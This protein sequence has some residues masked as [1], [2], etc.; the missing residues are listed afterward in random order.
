MHQIMPNG[1][2]KPLTDQL[3][4]LLQEQLLK[5]HASITYVHLQT[6]EKLQGVAFKAPSSTV[7]KV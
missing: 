5:V 2:K 3:A 1:V 7:Q 6:S 4:G